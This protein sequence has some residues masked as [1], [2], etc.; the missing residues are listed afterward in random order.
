MKCNT[1]ESN[2]WRKQSKSKFF[3]SLEISKKINDTLPTIPSTLPVKTLLFSMSYHANHYLRTLPPPKKKQ[4]K[5]LP[6]PPY[7]NT[8]ARGHSPRGKNH[9]IRDLWLQENGSP[10]RK[11]IKE[12]LDSACKTMPPAG[13]LL[14]FSKRPE[15]AANVTQFT[16]IPWTSWT[17]RQSGPAW[18]LAAALQ[19]TVWCRA[20]TTWVTMKNV[21]Q[22]SGWRTP[23]LPLSCTSLCHFV[24]L[25]STLLRQL[26]TWNPWRSNF[27]ACSNAPA[28]SK[29]S[30]GCSWRVPPECS[31]FLH[32]MYGAFSHALRL[33]VAI[34][35]MCIYILYISYHM[36]TYIY[37]CISIHVC[38]GLNL[39]SLYWGWLSHA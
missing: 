7:L 39:N 20:P 2:F 25:K 26:V 5:P 36:N 6:S 22:D 27:S 29:F 28:V 30:Q 21:T 35:Y 33:Y 1:C 37:I 13:F 15:M 11:S 19:H 14:I 32:G 31:I 9:S 17:S 16:G 8:N 4:L 23:N 12:R 3:P 24:L 34:W 38:Q 10:F 18:Y